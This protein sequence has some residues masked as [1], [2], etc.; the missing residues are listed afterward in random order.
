MAQRKQGKRGTARN[1]NIIQGSNGFTINGGTYANGDAPTTNQYNL[2]VINVN[3]SPSLGNG[4]KFEFA[5]FN[6]VHAGPHIGFNSATF[7]PRLTERSTL[8]AH[9][10]M[11]PQ[12]V[13]DKCKKRYM[14]HF[15]RHEQEESRTMHVQERE[16]NVISKARGPNHLN[17]V[18]KN[19]P[20]SQAATFLN[21]A[22]HSNALL[23]LGGLLEQL[24]CRLVFELAVDD[25]ALD[26]DGEEEVA[27]EAEALEQGV[28]QSRTYSSIRN[29]SLLSKLP[30]RSRSAKK[31]S[32]AP[33]PPGTPTRQ[34]LYP[35][36]SP[37][38]LDT[39]ALRSASS[40]LFSMVVCQRFVQWDER[41]KGKMRS[42]WGCSAMSFEVPVWHWVHEGCSQPKPVS[43]MHVRETCKNLVVVREIG[44][45][46]REVLNRGDVPGGEDQIG[47]VVRCQFESGEVGEGADDPLDGAEGS[48]G[49]RFSVPTGASKYPSTVPLWPATPLMRSFAQRPS[50]HNA[51]TSPSCHPPLGTN[52]RAQELHIRVFLVLSARVHPGDELSMTLLSPSKITTLDPDEDDNES[53]LAPALALNSN[54]L[55]VDE[56]FG[57]D[58]CG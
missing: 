43:P 45:N 56:V 17:V 32:F 29:A 6:A 54:P 34:L 27:V 9:T 5:E 49:G 55:R 51:F 48:G 26:E 50:I 31:G 57:P 13:N 41:G 7:V 8:I 18:S 52:Q 15:Q 3:G 33:S 30:N 46:G 19:I 42:N 37:L 25:L 1:R 38:D 24:A 23:T 16:M 35:P 10:A 53:G 44:C 47:D 12:L 21:L 4:P 39:P 40:I 58:G 2:L 20:L 28:A 36:K 11:K 14:T 22:N